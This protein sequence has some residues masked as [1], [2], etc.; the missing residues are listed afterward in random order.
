MTSFPGSPR[1]LKGAIVSLDKFNPQSS[2]VVFQYNPDTMSRS[3]SPRISKV[4][5]QEDAPSPK[6]TLR[7]TGPPEETIRLKIELDATDQLET[8]N[9][10]A[11][12]LGI[13]PQ[14]AALEILLYPKLTTVLSNQVL[15][16][17]GT[18]EVIPMELPL[19]LFM[20]GN[21]RTLPVRLESLSIEEQAFDV[22]L[23]P[24][25]AEISLSLRV[26][27][28]SDLQFGSKGGSLFLAHQVQKELL[29]AT[30]SAVNTIA[31]G[32]GSV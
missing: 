4:D 29:A 30:A 3:L 6:E 9:P 19:A 25:R 1:L 15:A 20:W 11:I 26:L 8:A 13:H 27:S 7:I 10:V 2:V 22:N 18:L 31:Q 17:T 21:K 16:K 32:T 23:N 28:Y 12:E 5:S 14:L 24:I